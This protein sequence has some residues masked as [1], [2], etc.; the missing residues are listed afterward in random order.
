MF[1]AAAAIGNAIFD[2]TGVPMNDL[3]YRL[4]RVERALRRT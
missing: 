1:N 4:P 2:A 3:P